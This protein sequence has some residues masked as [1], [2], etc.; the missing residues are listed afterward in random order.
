MADLAVGS[1]FEIFNWLITARP[2]T[3]L[4]MYERVGKFTV[5][6]KKTAALILKWNAK[7]EMKYMET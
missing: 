6:E 5:T 3:P 2:Q 7:V 1:E 4:R